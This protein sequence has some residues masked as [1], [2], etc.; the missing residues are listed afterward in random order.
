MSEQEQTRPGAPLPPEEQP[1]ERI[2]VALDASP[3]SFAALKAAVELAALLEADVEGLFIEDINLLNLCSFPFS[4]EVGSYTAQ[5]RPLEN[6]NLERQLRT[7]AWSIQERM[8]RVAA[9]TPVRWSFRVRRGP[10]VS[11]LLEAARNAALI[12]LG[13][14]GQ[15]RRTTLGS[16]ARS[17]LSQSRRPLLLLGEGAGLA[18]PLTVLYTG[19][20]AAQRALDLAARLARRHSSPVRVLL[21]SDSPAPGTPAGDLPD[22]DQ[23]Q[24]QAQAYLDMLNAAG[25]Y[26][27][28]HRSADLS[29]TLR[30]NDGGTLF[31]PGEHADLVAQH[32]GP[33][34]LVP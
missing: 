33:A 26:L 17:L 20:P 32:S 16:T 1:V 28:I 19:S 7:L 24:A 14:A 27:V 34:L 4:R 22:A 5:M 15:V 11:E 8:K 10:V 3:Q 29:A 31:L 2:V 23:L 21:W 13:R 25:V 9:Q 30:L 12:S 18:Y 6:A